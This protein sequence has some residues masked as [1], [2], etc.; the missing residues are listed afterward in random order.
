MS[1]T[2]KVKPPKN[3]AEWARN[4]EKRL[5]QTE[6]PTSTRVGN[7]VLSTHPDTGALIA[8]NVNGGSVVLA[9]QPKPSDDADQ[10]SGTT[11]PHIKVERQLNQVGNRG[12]TS[13][14]LWDTVVSQTKDDKWGFAPTGSDIVVP[15]DG[16]YLCTL[17]VAFKNASDVR[18]IGMFMIDGVIR[19]AQE[20]NPSD[21]WFQAMYMVDTFPLIA[22]SVITA[23][24]YVEGS[25]TFDVGVSTAT[26]HAFTSLSLTRIPVG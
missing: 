22:R 24:A 2:A 8:S 26:T 1:G 11:F 13:L 16:T 9:E 6:N 21:A 25:G 12:T 17:H 3:N 18:N 20:Y 10:V 14:I 19:M 4:T 15:E 23:G 5:N 7:W